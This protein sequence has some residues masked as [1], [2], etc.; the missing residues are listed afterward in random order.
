MPSSNPQIIGGGIQAGGTF[1]MNQLLYVTNVNPAQASTWGP[2]VATDAVSAVVYTAFPNS[3][4]TFVTTTNLNETVR[5]KGGAVIEGSGT[6][7]VQIGGGALA[8]ATDTIAIGRAAISDTTQTIVIGAGASNT[9][10]T[11]QQG[12]IVGYAATMNNAAGVVIGHS[13]AVSG[14]AGSAAGVVIGAAATGANS[15]NGG[16]T[17]T[18]IGHNAH[19]VAEDVVIGGNASSNVNNAAGVG[20]VIIGTSANANISGGSVFAVVVGWNASTTHKLSTVIGSGASATGASKTRAI[21]IGSAATVSATDAILIG[22]GGT[23]TTVS[24]AIGAAAAD[25]G[26]GVIQLGTSGTPITTVNIGAGNTIAS[27]V[28]KTV[29]FTNASG[30]DNAAGDVTFQAALSTGNAAEGRLLFKIGQQVAG[31]SS[32]LQTSTLVLTLSCNTG[33]PVAT[34]T[35]AVVTGAPSGGTAA[36]WKLGSIVAAAVVFDATRY[37]E[38]D[39]G[40]TLCKLSLVT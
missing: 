6:T 24:I 1:G 21:V 12:V 34:F 35:G 17:V 26:A 27:P 15:A 4:G 39:V 38:L 33:G 32:T 40:G 36:Q 25:M 18:V 19:G 7:S 22:G 16:G 30:T 9:I 2:K 29:R 20:S 5:I 13:A 8:S 10:G 37:V 11:G 3:T 23:L 28:A 31:S 14:N